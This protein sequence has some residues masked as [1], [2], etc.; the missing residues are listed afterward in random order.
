MGIRDATIRSKEAHN[1]AFSQGN[2][3]KAIRLAQ[4]SNRICLALATIESAA[5]RRNTRIRIE[6]AGAFT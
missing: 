3:E 4:F 5:H 2:R 6:S 1:A